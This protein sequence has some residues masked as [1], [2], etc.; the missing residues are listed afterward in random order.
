MVNLLR[1]VFGFNGAAGIQ[2]NGTSA[3]VVVNNTALLN[4]NTAL[5]AITAAEY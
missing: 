1:D 5:S 4:N 3:A 2:A